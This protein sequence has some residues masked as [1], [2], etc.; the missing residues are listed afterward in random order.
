MKWQN[1][2]H[3]LDEIGKKLSRKKKIIFMGISENVVELYK[4]IVFLGCPMLFCDESRVGEKIN[5]SDI[6]SWND[7]S[8]GIL[9]DSVIVLT[10][11]DKNAI[12]MSKKRLLMQGLCE[13]LDFFEYETFKRIYLP[14]WTLYAF[15]KCYVEHMGHAIGNACTLNCEKCSACIPYLKGK[16]KDPSGEQL[17]EEM[18]L[19]FSKVDFCY[20]WD[21]T[22]GETFLYSD[23]LAEYL[24]YLLNNYGT[25]IGEILMVSNATV[26]PS[27]KLLRLLVEIK[28]IVTIQ[29]SYYE[30]VPGWMEK[31]SL[32]KQVMD[33][34]GIP[35][36]VTPV[37][38]WIDF[39]FETTT[40]DKNEDELVAYFDNCGDFCR[41]YYNGK[42]YYCLHGHNNM[43]LHYPEE[44]DDEECID[45]RSDSVTPA[46]ITEWLL[47]FQPSGYLKMCR[48]CNGWGSANRH[49]IP[50]AKQIG[51]C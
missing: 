6:V 50:V 34:W 13:N 49:F 41:S 19:F 16:V 10:D 38:A 24:L 5:D 25:K 15:D 2:G 39:G 7:I 36:C 43:L 14:I 4:R 20:S 17:K 42:L 40:L 12:I 23:K 45:L 30:N 51:D 8:E 47:G 29:V 37:G 31:F 48:H 27:E 35:Y 46:I 22:S 21:C 9:E 28:D 26:I 32:F 3:E 33:E 1:K 44:N 11:V 18:D